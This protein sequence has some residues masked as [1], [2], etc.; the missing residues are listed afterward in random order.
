MLR[1]VM[2]TA[3]EEQVDLFEYFED[4]EKAFDRVQHEK[5]ME[6]LRELGVDMDE[7]RV[8]T[9]SYWEQ[10]LVVR[11]GEDKS[12]WIRIQKGVRQSFLFIFPSAYG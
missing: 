2:K 7:L 5:R 12:G 10:K 8:M 1:L 4:F 3:I 11:F 6:R 9:D